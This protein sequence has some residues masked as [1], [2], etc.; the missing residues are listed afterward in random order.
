MRPQY[1]ETVKFE[2]APRSGTAKTES[3]VLRFTR[4]NV[5]H[6]AYETLAELGKAVRTILL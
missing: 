2:I 3:I 6:P 1:D 4:A 5:Q